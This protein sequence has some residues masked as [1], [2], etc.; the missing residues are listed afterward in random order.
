M[1]C[2]CGKCRKMLQ[3][4]K[5]KN[6]PTNAEEAWKPSAH[7]SWCQLLAT[8]QTQPKMPTWKSTEIPGPQSSN[9]VHETQL[10]I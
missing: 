7:W 8:L 3:R 1:G 5:A 10:S 6:L 4:N 2:I 9:P